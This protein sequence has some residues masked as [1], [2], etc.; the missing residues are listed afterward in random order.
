MGDVDVVEQCEFDLAEAHF[1]DQSRLVGF[2]YFDADTRIGFRKGVYERGQID[3]CERCIA[4]QF[5]FARQLSAQGSGICF[6]FLGVA[7][8]AAR[9]CN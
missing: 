5:Q 3:R 7:K 9:L 1:L 8:Q 4:T 6:E 2:Q